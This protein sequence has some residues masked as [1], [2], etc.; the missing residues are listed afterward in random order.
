MRILF[1]YAKFESPYHG[2]RKFEV[3]FSRDRHFSAN[4]DGDLLEEPASVPVPEDFW[5][6]G[7]QIYNVSALVG[8]NAAGKTTIL[9]YLASLLDSIASSQSSSFKNFAFVDHFGILVIE[10]HNGAIFQI[11]Y[12][13]SNT[14]SFQVSELQSDNNYI[15]ISNN[16]VI[17]QL[18]AL[19]PIVLSNTLSPQD[20]VF[21][22]RYLTDASF[23]EEK[24]LRHPYIYDASTVS[25]LLNTNS[26][27]HNTREHLFMNYFLEEQHRQ[28]QFVFD[29]KFYHQLMLLK[30]AGH[31]VPYASSINFG[32]LKRDI[33][34]PTFTRNQLRSFFPTSYQFITN[35]PKPHNRDSY[36]SN[37]L[38][39]QLCHFTLFN[40]LYAVQDALRNFTVTPPS[41][42]TLIKRIPSDQ[43]PSHTFHNT[44]VLQ[45]DEFIFFLDNLYRIISELSFCSP[46]S[47]QQSD[48]I[49][50]TVLVVYSRT[51]QFIEYL[52]SNYANLTPYFDFT[53][54]R[55]DFSSY[56]E[57]FPEIIQFNVSTQHDDPTSDHPFAEFLDNYYV[58]CAPSYY[59]SFGW[60]LSSGE[61]TLLGIYANLHFL[62]QPRDLDGARTNRIS[63][64]IPGSLD[65]VN[66]DSIL[67]MID[68]ADMTLHPEWQR[69]FLA[70]L[71]AFLPKLYPEIKDIQIIL[72]THS[73]LMLGD[74]PSQCVTYF[75]KDENGEVTSDTSGTRFTFGQ[76]IYL[77][78]KDSFYLEDSALGPIAQRKLQA[79]IE[80]LKAIP[81]KADDLP[82]EAIN[83]HLNTLDKIQHE[84]VDLLAPGII[85]SKLKEEIERRRVVLQALLPI[86]YTQLSLEE[87]KRQQTAINA[88]IEKKEALRT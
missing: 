75:S 87:L 8:R 74:I 48:N 24:N 40:S 70:G 20:Y 63:N 13:A 57:D 15:K 79:V 58:Q 81:E 18:L 2:F 39:W 28:V 5:D 51:K 4:D 26:N 46:D 36:Y 72:T 77:L 73:P 14:L 12:S 32:F 22:R 85:K 60:N 66:C 56:E 82:A 49:L 17:P 6:E 23:P 88:A 41:I 55:L 53:D 54:I 68:E 35:Y 19:K 61:N 34:H 42:G 69:K 1:L 59:L 84:T 10:N 16:T 67:L 9:Q 64:F 47:N 76:N 7:K 44:T 27:P 30:Q 37:L 21:A 65:P 83:A 62:Y 86:D 3:N 50:H 11:K 38:L 45:P 43:S 33:K 80:Q 71:T 25:W 29:S 78:L 52:F 31:P